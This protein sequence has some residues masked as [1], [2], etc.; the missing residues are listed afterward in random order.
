MVPGSFG[1][2]HPFAPRHFDISVSW[3][4]KM[5]NGILV[6]SYFLDVLFFVRYNKSKQLT[7]VGI[8]AEAVP[9]KAED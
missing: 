5:N 7:Q 6:F 8:P 1:I 3:I 9:A 4:R 2:K